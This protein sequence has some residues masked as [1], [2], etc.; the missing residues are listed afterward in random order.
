MHPVVE[1]RQQS[2]IVSRRLGRTEGRDPAIP[3]AGQEQVRTMDH[4]Q[5]LRMTVTW[6]GAST[7]V[8]VK[9]RKRLFV[10]LTHR[11]AVPLGPIDEVFRPSKE[12]A[13]INGGVPY[14]R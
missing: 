11:Q 9:S 4:F 1:G 7:E 5:P 2:G 6:A 12:S 13:S 8:A 3:Q 10:Q 14:L